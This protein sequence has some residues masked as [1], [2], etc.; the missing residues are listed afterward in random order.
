M[1]RENRGR[2]LYLC[3]WAQGDSR[4][5]VRIMGKLDKGVE[6]KGLTLLV[7]FSMRAFMPGQAEGE[8][9]FSEPMKNR[10]PLFGWVDQLAVTALTIY[11]RH[12][13]PHKGWCCAYRA[14]TGE[15][16]CSEYAKVTIQ[17]FGFRSSLP[18]IKGRLMSCAHASRS[19]VHQSERGESTRGAGMKQDVAAEV[20]C[21]ACSCLPWLK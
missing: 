21:T 15:E 7:L 19:V 12:V 6:S 16:S 3:F 13:S 14:T 18:I 4:R 9:V 10:A 5:S 1:N 2:P 17:R 8:N 11:Q 20:A